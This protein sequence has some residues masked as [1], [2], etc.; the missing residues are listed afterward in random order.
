M[1]KLVFVAVLAAAAVFPA[2][3]FAAISGVVVG[4]SSGSIAVASKGGGVHTIRTRSHVR[5]GSRVRVDRAAVRVVGRAHAVRVHAV[6]VRRARGTVFLASDRSLFAVHGGRTAL[7]ATTTTATTA[8]EAAA[9]ATATSS[10]LSPHGRPASGAAG[11]SAGELFVEHG[12]MIFGLCRLLLR[13]PVDAEDAVQQVFL[14]AHRSVAAGSP[15]RDP[16]AWLAAIARNECRAGIRARMR[17][18][19]EL[20]ELPDDLPDPLAAAIRGADLDALWRGLAALPR[21]Q[22]RCSCCVSSA[23]CRTASSARRSVLVGRLS[24]RCCFVRG[25]GYAAC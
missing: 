25:S 5:I 24:N 18:P 3:A 17:A 11:L 2:G 8:E 1:K 12:R 10:E 16:A 19:L 6:V 13:D 22:R 4:K 14:A 21:R 7:V 20:P 23:G 9:T 15:P